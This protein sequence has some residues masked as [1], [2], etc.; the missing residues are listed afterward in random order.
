M[1]KDSF[2]FCRQGAEERTYHLICHD[3][4]VNLSIEV[5]PVEHIQLDDITRIGFTMNL[6][7]ESTLAICP[8]RLG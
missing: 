1:S 4:I 7:C 3:R 6:P 5:C 8:K 2:G